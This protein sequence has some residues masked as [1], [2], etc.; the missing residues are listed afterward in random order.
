[1]SRSQENSALLSTKVHSIEAK[2][3]STRQQ[4]AHEVSTTNAIFR[5]S[6]V[7]PSLSTQENSSKAASYSSAEAGLGRNPEQFIPQLQA[8]YYPPTVP[9]AGKSRSFL[10]LFNY[11]L[12]V[13]SCK[14]KAVNGF[15]YFSECALVRN[16][17]TTTTVWRFSNF[18]C[19][20]EGANLGLFHR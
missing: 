2:T 6:K 18:S 5:P 10:R 15:Y 9:T 14:P 12:C 11:L 20:I 16:I 7:F 13:S 1:M 4:F 17:T 8:H 19:M 3:G